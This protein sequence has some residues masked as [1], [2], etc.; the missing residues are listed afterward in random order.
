MPDYAD[1]TLPTLLNHHDP[2]VKGAGDFVLPD[3]NGCGLSSIPALVSTLLGGPPLQ[4][5]SMAPQISDQLG[6]QY[7]NVVL[8][9]VDA[10]GYDHFLRL[11]AQGYAEF[12]RERLPQASL[13]TLSS[14]C[15]S[16]TA[17]A[18]TTLW[19]GTNPPPHGYIGFEMWLKKYSMTINS[20]LIAHQFLSETMWFAACRFIGDSF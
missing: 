14:V 10:L 9:L 12:W 16:T 2:L 11:M 5:P 1:L 4:T 6:Q 8:I 18:L 15:P 17:T 20:I 3:Y 13:F 7:Q 19:T